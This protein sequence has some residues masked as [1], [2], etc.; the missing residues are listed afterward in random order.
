ML[1][2][3]GVNVSTQRNVRL[4][5]V[6][7]FDNGP[8]PRSSFSSLLSSPLPLLRRARTGGTTFNGLSAAGFPA[9]AAGEQ[10]G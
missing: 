7:E 1:K 8:I 3:V 4:D 6:V 10:C 9:A 2:T 5:V